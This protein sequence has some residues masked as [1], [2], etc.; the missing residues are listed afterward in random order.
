M[1]SL[2][3]QWF[4]Y[5][6]L[7]HHWLRCAQCILN[8][9]EQF[10][11]YEVPCSYFSLILIWEA[12]KIWLEG[13]EWQ[14]KK[15]LLKQVPHKMQKHLGMGCKMFYRSTNTIQITNK[16]TKDIPCTYFLVPD[17]NCPELIEF[18]LFITRK[19]LLIDTDCS[20]WRKCSSKY[21]A[22]A[23]MRIFITYIYLYWNAKKGLKELQWP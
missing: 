15:E 9:I 7:Q 21:L 3:L 18:F 22:K 1:F 2:S 13:F 19:W 10:N 6:I 23:I 12:F 14:S 16:A 20:H 5:F 11:I 17:I 4:L 8:C